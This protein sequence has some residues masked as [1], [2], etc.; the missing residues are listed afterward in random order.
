VTAFSVDYTKTGNYPTEDDDGESY[1]LAATQQLDAYG[2][3]LYALY[4]NYSLDRDVEPD[5][6]DMDVFSLGA[7]VKF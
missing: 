7:M 6:Q 5:V 1:A 3:E 2:T 4:R